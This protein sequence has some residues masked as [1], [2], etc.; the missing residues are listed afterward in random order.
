MSTPPGARLQERLRGNDEFKAEICATRPIREAV[1]SAADKPELCG[2]PNGA[3]TLVVTNQVA[4]ALWHSETPD[5]RTVESQHE[6]VQVALRSI[7][8]RDAIEGM[9]AAQMVATHEAAMECFRRA[10]LPS[11]PS[12][13]GA[14]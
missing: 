7:A 1:A 14:S 5:P 6:A 4:R 12:R 2:S 3:F 10:M 9:L 13:A 8:P 11:R